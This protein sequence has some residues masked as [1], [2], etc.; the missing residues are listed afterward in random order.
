[1]I[2]FS[3]L[4][5][6]VVAL[7]TSACA[8]AA[9]SATNHGTTTPA[10]SPSTRTLAAA[11][12]PPV[13]ASVTDNSQNP[14]AAQPPV[15][16]SGHIVCGSTVRTGVNESPADGGPVRVRTRGWAWQ[17]TATMSDPRLEGDY[18]VS[19]DSDDYESPTVTSVG[20]GTWRIEN[21]EG[22]WL[23]SFTNIKYPDS[24]TI[25]STALVGEGA[26]EGLTAVWESTNHRPLECAWDV[27]GLILEGDVPAAPE[28]Y[29][30]Q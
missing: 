28:P 29:T 14:A 17:P 7:L 10:V 5:A 20:S 24:T 4:T 3:R 22:A 6:V 30:G 1:M 8:A 27:R 26:Y 21:E 15:A 13:A 9:P 18:Y 25:V 19:Y 2:R 16:F 23:G 11:T 12:S